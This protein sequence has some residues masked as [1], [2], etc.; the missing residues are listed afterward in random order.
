MINLTKLENVMNLNNKKIYLIEKRVFMRLMTFQV[1]K[2]KKK[3]YIHNS[4]SY[5]IINQLI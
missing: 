3:Y 2:L 4:K 1:K 5:N